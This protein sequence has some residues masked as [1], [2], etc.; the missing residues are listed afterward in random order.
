MEYRQVIPLCEACLPFGKDINKMD[1]ELIMQVAGVGLLLAVTCQILSKSG[2]DD[3]AMLLSIAGIVVV[4]IML[5]GKVGDL[6]NV[7]RQTFGI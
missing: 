4:L 5:I 7:V 1:V 6:I 3:Q 2:R